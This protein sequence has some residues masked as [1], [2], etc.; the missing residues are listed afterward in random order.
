MTRMRNQLV[1]VVAL[2]ALLLLTLTPAGATG[3]ARLD[4]RLIGI[5]GRPAAGMTMHLIDGD[6][7]GIATSETDRDGFYGFG[8]LDAGDYALGVQT[9]EGMTPV[10]ASGVRLA[11]NELARRDVQLRGAELGDHERAAQGN[12]GLGMWWA[13]LSTA[14]KIWTIV[15][16]VIIIGVTAAALSDDDDDEPDA[17]PF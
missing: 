8:D 12:Y 13:G 7:I 2:P 9:P 3:G 4:G 16:G 15:G 14:A 6:G 10:A 11:S 5:D 1:A 17:S